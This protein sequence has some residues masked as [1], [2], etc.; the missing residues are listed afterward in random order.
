MNTDNGRP[1]AV[2]W[3]NGTIIDLTPGA[4]TATAYTIN[5]SGLVVGAISS[6]S[7]SG[8][9]RAFYWQNGVLTVIDPSVCPLCGSGSL[10]R[11][12]NQAG[13]IAIES[14]TT[15]NAK[16]ANLLV[17]RRIDHAPWRWGAPLP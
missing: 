5:D 9:Y 6:S 7:D 11:D 12:V 8:S 16:T 1:H 13:V 15:T 4:Y 3:Q 17:Q 14:G 2:L 10:A